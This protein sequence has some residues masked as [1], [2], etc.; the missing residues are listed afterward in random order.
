VPALKLPSHAA[1]GNVEVVSDATWKLPISDRTYL[2]GTGRVL[3]TK[4]S[5]TRTLPDERFATLT[6]GGQIIKPKPLL[7]ARKACTI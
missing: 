2:T 5:P 4:H 3:D 7:I 6:A 1:A